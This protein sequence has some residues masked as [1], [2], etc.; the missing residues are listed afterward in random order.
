MPDITLHSPDEFL[1]AFREDPTNA[2]LALYAGAA[3]DRAGRA[4]EALAVWTLG[5][6]ANPALRR[7]RLHPEADGDLRAHSERADA[8]IRNHFTSLHR[9]TIDDY[10]RTLDHDDLDRVRA[11][12]WPHYAVESFKCRD[13]KQRPQIFYMPDLPIRPVTPNDMLPWVGAIEAAHREIRREFEKAVSENV[14]QHPY[15]SE[16]VEGEHWG[17][18][19]GK[20]DWSALYI[21]FNAET[22]KEASALPKTIDAL[23]AA[24]LVCRDGVPLETFFSCLKS[25]VHIPPHYGLTNSRLTVHL[26]L[27]VPEGCEIRVGDE[28]YQWEEGRIIAFDDSFE[29]EVWNRSDRERVVLIFETYHPDLSPTEVEAIERVYAAFNK[30]VAGRRASIGLKEADGAN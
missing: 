25:G 21:H 10:A 30:W 1:E 13:P 7:V 29:H 24:K 8:A 4:E 5:D 6:D 17:K 27:I 14:K 9:K 19:R 11:G 18:L 16:D 26:P 3:L 2:P 23:N 28:F 22:T 20:L 12:V 15:V